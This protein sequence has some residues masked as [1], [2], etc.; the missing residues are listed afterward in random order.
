MKMSDLT[1]ERIEN[2]DPMNSRAKSNGMVTEWVARN[3]FGNAIAFGNTKAE[4]QADAIRFL[5][6]ENAK[7]GGRRP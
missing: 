5:N 3:M 4:C 2:Y 1:F 7:K 6:M